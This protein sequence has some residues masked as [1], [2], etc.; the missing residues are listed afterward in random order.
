LRSSSWRHSGGPPLALRGYHLHEVIERIKVRID[1][2]PYRSNKRYVAVGRNHS[3]RRKD[4]VG[5]HEFDTSVESDTE[6]GC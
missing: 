1:A 4:V 5:D 2:V 6:D 3:P